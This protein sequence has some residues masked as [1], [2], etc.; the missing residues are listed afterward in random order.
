MHLCTYAPMHLCTYA[1]LK[2]SLPLCTSAH[3]PHLHPC[4]TPSSLQLCSSAALQ[5]C[6]SAALQ[7]CIWKNHMMR[8]SLEFQG[9]SLWH[10]L[11][12]MPAQ[13]FFTF[14]AFLASSHKFTCFF[15]AFCA[16][17]LAFSCT[18][19]TSCIIAHLLSILKNPC[20]FSHNV[21]AQCI[22]P[23]VVN[24][25]SLHPLCTSAPAPLHHCTIRSTIK[26]PRID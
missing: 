2:A 6:S 1:L 17:L 7:L 8:I 4:T 3:H 23:S 18:S 14:L 25:A 13:T 9:Y 26:G 12:C 19:H 21:G 11:P 22:C 10:F 5:L 16:S 15:L 20:I 24:R